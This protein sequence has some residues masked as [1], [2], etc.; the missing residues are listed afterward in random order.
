[1]ATLPLPTLAAQISATGISAPAFENVLNSEIATYQSIYGSDSVLT[2]DTQDGQLLS[3]RATAINDLNQLA[4]AVYNSF[5]PDFAQGAGLDARVQINGLQ[6][7]SPT[8]STVLL[9][10]V[11]VVG[12]IIENGVAADTAGNLWNLPA[13][14]TIPIS[15][16]IEVTA[17]A[18]EAGAIAAP[19]G[20]VNQP[21]TIITGWQS[22]TNPAAATPGIAVE[23]DAAL[24]R[25]QAAST[26]L[27]A[28][29]PLQ[30]I[31]AAV[32]NL[33]GVG[34]ILPYEN[35]NAT[36]D[37][38]GVPSH[39]IALV[40]E[41]GD[42]TQIAQ[43]I[44][45]KKAPGT[46]TF[47]NTSIIVSDPAGVP[48]NISFF[49]LTEVPIFVSIT[50]QPL[51]GFVS[52]TGTAIINAVVSFLNSLPIGQEVFLNWLLAVA[53]LNGSALG[54]TF[55]I[56]SL[57]IGINAGFLTA[58]NVTIAFNAAASCQAS[59]VTLVVL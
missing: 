58:A 31:A 24:R 51:N 48:I 44:E 4:I 26:S 13:Q 29:T 53:G 47:G 9:N 38:N 46:G 7:I 20:T 6:R 57:E 5:S 59:D 40:V 52:T 42:A 28:Q 14:V 10:I 27:P 12:T 30:S 21:F 32:A 49:E 8:N 17:T 43:T 56:T 34:R 37:A 19:A 3:I 39:S 16:L 15:G 33:I 22:C 55:A 45:Q 1:M 54:L 2:P 36:T 50:I 41:G 18:Q 35:Q 23:I 11:G 25:R